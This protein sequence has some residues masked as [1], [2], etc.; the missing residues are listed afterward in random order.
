M[1]V[2][3]RSFAKVIEPCVYVVGSFASFCFGK[4]GAMEKEE[5]WRSV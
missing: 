3:A 4:G 2:K 5:L 1:K